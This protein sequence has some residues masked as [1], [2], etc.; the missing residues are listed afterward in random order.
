[1]GDLLQGCIWDGQAT[2]HRQQHNLPCNFL[3]CSLAMLLSTN[4]TEKPTAPQHLSHKLERLLLP[5]MPLMKTQPKECF[6]MG[7]SHVDGQVLR[8]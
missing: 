7:W 8:V 5:A 4:S 1:M 6:L 3:G 2:G